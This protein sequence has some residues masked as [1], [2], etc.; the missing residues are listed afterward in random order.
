MEVLM[1]A[2]LAI[3]LAGCSH[4]LEGPYTAEVTTTLD[5]I[6]TETLEEIEIVERDLGDNERGL[7]RIFDEPCEL[8]MFKR[9][10]YGL[11]LVAGTT[12]GRDGESWTIVSG[13]VP[14]DD[15]ATIVMDLAWD[16]DGRTATETL[17]FER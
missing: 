16:V 1:R 5:G 12:C 15:T 7:R 9:G 13:A 14:D 3:A 10:G 6:T 2:L 11:R 17:R 8:P 4:I